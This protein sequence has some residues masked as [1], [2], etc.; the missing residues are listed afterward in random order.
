MS[1]FL[2]VS[3]RLLNDFGQ[4]SKSLTGDFWRLWYSGVAATRDRLAR[5]AGG[6]STRFSSSR[7]PTSPGQALQERDVLVGRICL[8]LTGLK[9]L[10]TRVPRAVPWATMSR[11]FGTFRR[12]KRAGLFMI[13]ECGALFLIWRGGAAKLP[14]LVRSQVQ[15]GN[16]GTSSPDHRQLARRRSRRA[17]TF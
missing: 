17:Y 2:D 12:R 11:P 15:L 8:A 14:G 10:L 13:A 16:E 3:S 7:K 1:I 4:M 9:I 6:E 5:S